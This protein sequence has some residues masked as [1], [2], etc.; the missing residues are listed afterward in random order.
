MKCGALVAANVG[1]TANKEIKNM[2]MGGIDMF[3]VKKEELCM[4]GH[5]QMTEMAKMILGKIAYCNI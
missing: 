5:F 1:F 2:D 3:E 4:S